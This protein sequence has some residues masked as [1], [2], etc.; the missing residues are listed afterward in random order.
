VNIFLSRLLDVRA[1][2][3][4]GR[5]VVASGRVVEMARRWEA[6]EKL[7]TEENW[8]VGRFLRLS[9]D[10]S[11]PLAALNS[12]VLGQLEAWEK[13]DSATERELDIVLRD[14]GDLPDRTF[15]GLCLLIL[16]A[17]LRRGGNQKG[18]PDWLS[19]RVM[20]SVRDRAVDSAPVDLV[21]WIAG[22]LS[23]SVRRSFFEVFNPSANEKD[24]EGLC[25]GTDSL[26]ST[27]FSG[28]DSQDVYAAAES[29]VAT[30]E[31][32]SLW[33]L[34]E[35]WTGGGGPELAF[36]RIVC[37]L[38]SDH[39][40][41]DVFWLME[42]I[43]A[44]NAREEFR[45]EVALSAATVWTSEDRWYNCNLGPAHPV[46]AASLIRGIP[47]SEA[48]YEVE[49]MIIFW[50]RGWGGP[51]AEII[52]EGANRIE[53]EL[54]DF[55]GCPHAAVY[56]R[57][58]YHL[59]RLLAFLW[60]KCATG[61]A[62]AGRWREALEALHRVQSKTM[63]SFGLTEFFDEFS[64]RIPAECWR[65]I[66]SLVVR[67]I[68]DCVDVDNQ[69]RQLC[70]LMWLI[71]GKGVAEDE[72]WFL[73]LVEESCEGSEL[74]FGEQMLRSFRRGSVRYFA[75]SDEFEQ[76]L[77]CCAS[78]SD[79]MERKCCFEE[80]ELIAAR[81]REWSVCARVRAAR[82]AIEEREAERTREERARSVKLAGSSSF[83]A[84]EIEVRTN[85]SEWVIDTLKDEE[86]EGTEDLLGECV[87]LV[88]ERGCLETSDGLLTLLVA[89]RLVEMEDVETSR[90][91][92]TRLLSDFN[93]R[94]ARAY[95]VVMSGLTKKSE[96]VSWFAGKEMLEEI[97]SGNWVPTL[98]EKPK[99]LSKD[100]V[101]ND[102]RKT[103]TRYFDTSRVIA[104]E[105]WVQAFAATLTEAPD[106]AMLDRFLSQARPMCDETAWVAAVGKLRCELDDKGA[107][108]K[109]LQAFDRRLVEMG[110]AKAV[111][112]WR[113]LHL[114]S[115]RVDPKEWLQ[116][117]RDKP[118]AEAF[119]CVAE[120]P[121]TKESL[122][123]IGVLFERALTDE[124]VLWGVI[125]LAEAQSI[126]CAARRCSDVNECFRAL[127]L[128][129]LQLLDA[130]ED[131]SR[132]AQL[133]GRICEWDYGFN[134]RGFGAYTIGVA[135][136]WAGCGL[137]D[138]AVELVEDLPDRYR[139]SEG[140]A[141]LAIR[142][143]LVSGTLQGLELFNRF[144]GK[145]EGMRV[146]FDSFDG[147]RLIARGYADSG[148]EA[149]FCRV[150]ELILHWYF[151][152]PKIHRRQSMHSLLFDLASMFNQLGLVDQMID[153]LDRMLAELRDYGMV[154]GCFWSRLTEALEESQ[155]AFVGLTQ[156]Q[157]ERIL[158]LMAR[159]KRG[160]S[161]DEAIFLS[162]LMNGCQD[163]KS[164]LILW[165]DSV[166]DPCGFVDAMTL[167]SLIR[168]NVD[169][170][171]WSFAMVC[172]FDVE[173]N[174]RYVEWRV[175]EAILNR[176][177]GV[178]RSIHA[179]CPELE[180]DWALAIAG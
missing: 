97:L 75:E 17:E 106:A 64:E 60:R 133:V 149:M 89:D 14:W 152:W 153:F 173:A 16:A 66:S 158:R 175:R 126:W 159:E 1:A 118:W 154:M 80:I 102:F 59:S 180:L 90:N 145:F 142:V 74:A 73:E 165:R 117:L 12:T 87:A 76:A 100:G 138:R 105:R 124:K 38:A 120:A 92:L 144:V 8:E 115:V 55:L 139:Q 136:A 44:A 148:D 18:I 162:A 110:M 25:A 129:C 47:P 82:V 4:G 88:I 48:R 156:V 125:E 72:G 179:A 85:A 135:K 121:Q 84:L 49:V 57:M 81:K 53:Y 127:T 166:L 140:L 137:L 21:D 15:S 9:F 107:D 22:G 77:E 63:A 83:A 3:R 39:R 62:N 103:L 51:D 112:E 33:E 45:N 29:L 5:E 61:F 86:C 99:T 93:G 36:R 19:V 96:G 147:A 161:S 26:I 32:N 95:S 13:M 69:K 167:E 91:L 94:H 119:R 172:P 141:A 101:Y 70:R 28:V 7:V 111:E 43:R 35:G 168:C 34:F 170:V 30:R 164:L 146:R 150:V 128:T 177:W 46:E 178:L 27:L 11:A 37:A 130:V 176:D 23:T 160:D 123:G 6:I 131:R 122:A 10:A 157:R 109:L 171:G 65:G 56:P 163:P 50:M 114:Q 2:L 143:G 116:S 40:L 134:E 79:E 104:V 155:R 24:G 169:L 31:A 71:G 41:G 151:S 42:Q 52:R 132:R 58:S 113:A 78:D 20:D 54:A 108:F 67:L 98:P 68:A 174:R